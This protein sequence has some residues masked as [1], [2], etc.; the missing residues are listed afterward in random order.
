[1]KDLLE[2]I[3]TVKDKTVMT[4]AVVFATMVTAWTLA[5]VDEITIGVVAMVALNAWLVIEAVHFEGD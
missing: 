3:L 2:K 1:M 5:S 4:I